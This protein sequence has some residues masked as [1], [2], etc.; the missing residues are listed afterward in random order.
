MFRRSLDRVIDYL[1]LL[2]VLA[3]V[4]LSSGVM[5]VLLNIDN[6]I[7]R[8]YP[9]VP[10]MAYQSLTETLVVAMAYA[11]AA[12]GLVVILNFVASLKRPSRS[13]PAAIVIGVALLV[14][15]LMLLEIL[16]RIKRP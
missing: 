1:P 14:V 11:S 16:R 12:L 6:R 15:A 5:Y 9:I 2:A 8:D 10:D 7:V 13:S 4:V 3:A